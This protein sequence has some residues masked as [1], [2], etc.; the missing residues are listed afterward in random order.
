MR[1]LY[2]VLFSC[3]LAGCAAPSQEPGR[4]SATL[5]LSAKVAPQ[6]AAPA[7]TRRLVKRVA[8]DLRVRDTATASSDVQ[9][10]AAELGG[11]I[12]SMNAERHDS[13][14]VYQMTLRVPEGRLDE[15][16]TRIKTLG[17]VDRENVSAE[18]VTDQFVDLSARLKTL[19]ATE[20]ELRALL[21]ESRQRQQRAEDIMA[22][23]KQLTEIRSSIE[24]IR[25]QLN[26]IE[27]LAAMATITLNLVPIASPVVAVTSWQPSET[28]RR[29]FGMLISVLTG[30][31]DL[32]IT[33]G[34]VVIPPV[35]IL[36]LV[37]W[38]GIKAWRALRGRTGVTT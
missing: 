38:L 14:V 7:I 10:L 24:Q 34:I 16:V 18:D 6:E 37:C 26:V 15:A 32:V 29:S 35:L 28:V 33:L 23:Y 2:T 13:G 20:A 12:G 3:L 5:A 9:K 27:N 19:E 8:L 25:G 4:E 17:E 22:I 36:A 31:V 11:H 1:V 30:L 21:S